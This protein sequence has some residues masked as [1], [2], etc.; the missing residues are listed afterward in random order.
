MTESAQLQKRAAAAGWQW[1]IE[2]RPPE[3]ASAVSSLLQTARTLALGLLKGAL[4]I[5]LGA[6]TLMIFTNALL[7][8]GFGSGIVLADEM[9]RLFFVWITFL[10]SMLAL[11]DNE[12]IGVDILIRL[13]PNRAKLAI[14]MV[15]C[16]GILGLMVISGYGALALIESNKASTLPVSGLPVAM[17]F[18]P[19]LLFSVFVFLFVIIRMQAV[20]RCRVGIVGLLFMEDLSRGIKPSENGTSAG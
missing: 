10:G 12:H 3:H 17:Q 9:S 15:S 14:M 18:L 8:Y 1:R 19:V 16:I 2:P 20:F 11:V 5:L 13:V 7:R 6:L 4:I